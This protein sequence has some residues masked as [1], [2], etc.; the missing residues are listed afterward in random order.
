MQ[1]LRDLFHR[2]GCLSAEPRGQSQLER[3]AFLPGGQ[4]VGRPAQ[5]GQ[6]FR[7][8]SLGLGL[9]GFQS[10]LPRMI[11]SDLALHALEAFLVKG[12]TADGPRL[13]KHRQGGLVQRFQPPP[14]QVPL[15]RLATRRGV[16]RDSVFAQQTV[17]A[18]PPRPMLAGG[19]L[20]GETA[21]RIRQQAV[22]G[23]QAVRARTGL[24]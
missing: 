17:D 2:K 15:Q 10:G 14:F 11:L 13:A 6:F 5:A 4:I 20:P 23:G 19:Q 12:L 18:Q 7:H 9:R 3:M 22:L 16:L 24:R 21:P 8:E 1:A